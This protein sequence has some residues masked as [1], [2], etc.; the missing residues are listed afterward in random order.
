MKDYVVPYDMSAAIILHRE[1][2]KVNG[3]LYLVHQE[4]IF[5]KTLSVLG[6]STPTVHSS[7]NFAFIHKCRNGNG[8]LNKRK[9]V[10]Y[11]K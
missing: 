10:K 3:T 8:T 2:G 4:T 11:S 6:C 1:S 5:P 9:H 7:G